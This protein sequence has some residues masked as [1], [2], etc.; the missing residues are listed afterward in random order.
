M[1]LRVDLSRP[2]LFFCESRHWPVYG[3]MGPATPAPLGK[4]AEIVIER[5]P[6]PVRTGDGARHRCVDDPLSVERGAAIVP[7]VQ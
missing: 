1:V 3:A 5:Q 2:E 4:K 7:W 6:D